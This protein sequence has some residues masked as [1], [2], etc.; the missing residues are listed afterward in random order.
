[1]PH[2]MA[3]PWPISASPRTALAP[4]PIRSPASHATLFRSGQPAQAF[5]IVLSGRIE[6]HLTTTSGPKILLLYRV[7]PGQSCIQSTPGLLGDAD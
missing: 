7:A 1:M 2:A 6:V 4:L 3:P 5:V